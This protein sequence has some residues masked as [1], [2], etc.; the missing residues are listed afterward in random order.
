MKI[1]NF[2][3][4]LRLLGRFAI[5][6]V[7]VICAYI[8]AFYLRLS[9]KID[10]GYWHIII[11]TLPLLIFIKMVV[12]GYSGFFSEQ[13]GYFNI[14]Y[15]WKIL[16]AHLLSTISFITGI[17]FIYT[18]TGF[19]RSI[20]ILDGIFCF[21]L[22][23][24]IRFVAKLFRGGGGALL[25]AGAI[26]KNL[27]LFDICVITLVLPFSK[28]LTK[29]FFCLGIALWV[30]VNLIEYKSKFYKNLIPP[31]PLNITVILFLI[32]ALISVVFSINPG[33]S[34]EIFFGRYLLFVFFFWVCY[35]ILGYSKR[36]LIFILFSLLLSGAILGIGAI[37]DYF[38]FRPSQLSTVFNIKVNI[39]SCLTF[40]MP[41]S[42]TVFFSRSK[43]LFKYL[44]LT[45][46]ILLLPM[47]IF[48]ASRGVWVAI[49]ISLI[50]VSLFARIKYKI[51]FY[52][53]VIIVLF[54][55]PKLYKERA[56]TILDPFRQQSVIVRGELY[57]SAINIFKGRPLF[58]AGL[59]MFGKLFKN[60]SSEHSHVHNIYLEIAAEM[61]I[62]GLLAFFFILFIFLK[63][64]KENLFDWA[65]TGGRTRI[66]TTAAG[67][68]IFSSL[69]SN[70]STSSIMVGFQD[71]LIFWLLLAIAMNDKIENLT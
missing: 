33:K 60:G 48:H 50:I 35:A 18:V 44:S 1:E 49:L 6:L 58:G 46:I 69:I 41:L 30:I 34:Q 63:K 57:T 55:A 9:F 37:R 11:K 52:S 16:K 40:L 10:A 53:L 65:K 27:I 61:G 64:F 5:Y 19:P 62:I 38:L 23:L 36:N 7:L 67:A 32:S 29:V 22:I 20:F 66:I 70:I 15:I 54:C 2:V 14:A 13:W 42:F 31:S 26:F 71:P 43:K 45:S 25:W 68:S 17:V 12:F 24:V 8:L 56:K 3:P 39:A 21:C 51:I 59:G 4:K 47:F 28:S